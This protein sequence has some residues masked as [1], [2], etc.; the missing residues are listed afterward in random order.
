VQTWRPSILGVG[1]PGPWWWRVGVALPTFSGVGVLLP[2]SSS[3]AGG[4]VDTEGNKRERQ[5]K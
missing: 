5:R 4:P 3:I 2:G 1:Q